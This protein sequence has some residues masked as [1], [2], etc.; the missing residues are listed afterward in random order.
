MNG[1]Y[2]AITQNNTLL[3]NINTYVIILLKIHKYIIYIIKTR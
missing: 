1:I 3:Y 2:Q